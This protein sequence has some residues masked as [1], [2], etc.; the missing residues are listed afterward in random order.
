MDDKEL[1]ERAVKSRDVAAFN[2]LARQNQSKVRG[3]LLRLTRGNHALADDLAQETF[4]EAWRGIANFRGESSFSTWLYRI[5][6]RAFSCRRES[7]KPTSP[8][9]TGKEQR[10]AARARR[11]RASIS[12][13]P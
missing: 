3:L 8:S 2:L 1:V 6:Y 10:P 5:A 4:L 12:H 9:T 11:R 13:A 7:A